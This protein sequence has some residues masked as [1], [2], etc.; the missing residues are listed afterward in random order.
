[1]QSAVSESDSPTRALRTEMSDATFLE[2]AACGLEGIE[3]GR[4][5]AIDRDLQEDLLDLLLGEA[6]VQRAVDMQL[7]LGAAVER[8]QHGEVQHRAALFGEARSRPG[9]APAILGGDV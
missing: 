2:D 1:M 3:A 7:E 6:V 9:I 5:A 4:D 8:R